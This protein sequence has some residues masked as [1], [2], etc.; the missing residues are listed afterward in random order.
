MMVSELDLEVAYLLGPALLQVNYTQEQLIKYS[1]SP[2]I[3]NKVS[4]AASKRT[5]EAL[6]ITNRI[7]FGASQLFNPRGNIIIFT[8]EEIKEGYEYSELILGDNKDYYV[9][10]NKGNT[11]NEQDSKDKDK[12]KSTFI[13]V[14]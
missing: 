1:F 8:L 5:L 7:L 4:I 6:V 13:S 14:K 11:D 9:N 10:E 3:V 12:D 2:V